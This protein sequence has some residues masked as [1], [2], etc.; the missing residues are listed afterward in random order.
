MSSTPLPRRRLHW[1]PDT[2][3]GSWAVALAGLAV[4]GIVA[5]GVAFATGLE[6]ADGFTD[7]WFL[8][9]AGLTILASAAASALTGASALV[10]GHDRSG[11]AAAATAVGVLVT[12]LVLMQVAEG[13]GWLTG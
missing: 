3:V 11:G 10:R 6:S 5:L 9:V 4:G 7:N 2:R 12:G 13:L 1:A 8:T